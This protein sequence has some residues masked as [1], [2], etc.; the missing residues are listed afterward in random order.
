MSLPK[1][2]RQKM[3]NLMYLVLT[4][5]LALN[6]SSEIINAFKTINNSL[7]S[8][9]GVITEK[10]KSVYST[11]EKKLNDQQTKAQAA[12]WQPPALEAKRL[13]DEIYNYLEQIKSDLKKE[14]QLTIE[15][16]V[17]RFKEDDLDA[18][19]R[20]LVEGAKG[21]ELLAKLTTYKQNLIDVINPSKFSGQSAETLKKIT[22]AFENFKTSLPLDLTPPK[23]SSTHGEASTNKPW[24]SGY[25]RMT[26][27]VAAITMISKLQN[28]VKNSESQ[29]A[30]FCLKQVGAVEI[31]YDNF[32]AIASQS[33]EYLMPGQELTIRAGIGA[34]SKQAAPTVSIGGSV[35]PLNAEGVAEQKIKVGNT[36]TYSSIVNISFKKPD[37]T[38]GTA[39]KEIKYTVGSPTGL[40]ASAT[41]VNVLYNGI[42]NPVAI[43][44]GS[45]DEKITP[46]IDN[47]TITKKGGGMYE[48]NP[49][50]TG[51]AKISA[52]VDGKTSTFEFP[53]RRIPNPTPAVGQY[54][55]G[56]VPVNQFKAN[57]GVRADMGEFVFKSVKFNVISYTIVC[58]GRGFENGP[59]FGQVQGAYFTPE[60]KGYIE[61]CRPGSSVLITDISVSGPDGTRKL[62]GSLAFNLTN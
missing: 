12:L 23:Q 31:V 27:T 52:T 2:P 47:G 22:E 40:F 32:Q 38:I 14:S 11:F 44:G 10:N 37:G 7:V 16:G 42:P 8:A 60:V 6:V 41:E 20:L 59:K 13:S 39:Q 18:A 49:A 43:A 4:A 17:E 21:D 36:G 15:N 51:K 33:S 57:V 28:D 1:E 34:F 54:F 45:G 55:G 19:T 48:V 61:M 3:I 29:I 30:D 53:V 25:F 35:I 24:Q 46:S 26:P 62:P 58:T 5:L 50:S 56:S 9:N